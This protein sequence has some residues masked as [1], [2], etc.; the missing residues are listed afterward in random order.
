MHTLTCAD[1]ST[2][3]GTEFRALADGLFELPT[4]HR[5]A[6]QMPSPTLVAFRAPSSRLRVGRVPVRSR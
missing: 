3:P 6:T 1:C 2:G 5:L 4:G